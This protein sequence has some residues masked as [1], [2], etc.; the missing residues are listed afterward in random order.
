MGDSFKGES[1][2]GKQKAIDQHRNLAEQ[3]SKN[4]AQFIPRS[5]SHRDLLDI[6]D[7]LRSHG[8]SHYVDLPQIMYVAALPPSFSRNS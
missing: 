4:A 2:M 1:T 3:I 5:S 6:V 7:A 8:L